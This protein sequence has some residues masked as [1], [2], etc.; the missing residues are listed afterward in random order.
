MPAE[1]NYIDGTLRQGYFCSRCGQTTNMYGSGHQLC[2]SNPK[3][4][5]QLTRANPPPGIKPHFV[6]S[7]KS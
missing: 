7:Q 3:L 4:V 1:Y 6:L 2:T 5:E